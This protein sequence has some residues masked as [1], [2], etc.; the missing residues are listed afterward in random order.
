[1]PNVQGNGRKQRTLIA[2][3]LEWFYRNARD[4]PWRHTSD[5]YAIW[6]SEVMLQ[7]TQVKT[8]VPYWNR[9]M[10][11]LPT[12]NALAKARP[13]K[14]LKLWEGLGYYT[15]VGNL[16]KAARIIVTRHRRR[17]PTE[18]NEVLALPGVGR[19]TAGAV[20]SI[21]FNRPTPVLDGNVIRVLTRVFGIRQNPKKKM[22]NA[23]LWRIAETLMSHAVRIHPSVSR[24]FL[25]QPQGEGNQRTAAR[26]SDILSS[27]R[28]FLRSIGTCSALN[29][30]LMEFGA[31]ICTPRRPQCH[32]C[33]LRPS[34]MAYR[35]GLVEELPN[36]GRPLRT[37]SCR[38]AAFVFTHAGKVLVRQRPN[39]VVNAQLW[40]FPNVEMAPHDSDAL[41]IAATMVG[42]VRLRRLFEIKHSITRHRITVKVF[43]ADLSDL[44][45]KRIK[46]GRWRRLGDLSRLAFPSA[47]RKILERLKLKRDE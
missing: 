2:A 42:R 8:V 47:H 21:A 39:G 11:E 41:G 24:R 7:Q 29:Q 6:M 43:H 4:L 17:F 16:Q 18:L 23:R 45:R 22:T 12:V 36:R 27:N 5:P 35:D 26:N 20:C 34:C 9:W 33:P 38:C 15:R 10:R 46:Q 14:L 30:A 1:M 32:P 40:E 28:T 31:V 13:S 25:A 37:L 3:L 19:Y 44:Q